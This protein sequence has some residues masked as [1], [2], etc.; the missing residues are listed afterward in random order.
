MNAIVDESGVLSF[1]WQCLMPDL[2]F[3]S[4]IRIVHKPCV[5]FLHVL[6][7]S[8]VLN[9]NSAQILRRVHL[10]IIQRR[11]LSVASCFRTLVVCIVLIIT[12]A[13]VSSQR[14][15]KPAFFLLRIHDDTQ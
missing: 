1:R 4:V 8:R 7:R 6:V 2:H 12:C 5:Y 3:I 11:L 13:R 15:D 9:V 14:V 10:I